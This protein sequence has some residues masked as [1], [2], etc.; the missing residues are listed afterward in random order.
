MKQ[1]K[2]FAILAGIVIGSIAVRLY[3]INSPIADWHSW[4]QVDTAAVARNFEKFGTDPLHPRYNDLSNIQS[5]KDN[6][7][8]WRMVEFPI[9]QLFAIGSKRI[10][11]SITIE[12]A[13][14]IVSILATA[15][16]VL[17]LGLIGRKLQN[18]V[19]GLFISFFYAFLPY[20]IYYGRTTLPEPTGVFFSILSLLLAVYAFD[21]KNW[22]AII[23]LMGS[24]I[25]AALALLIKPF[26][27]FLLF[28]L[29]FLFLRNFKFSISWITK[30]IMYG[31]VSLL[32]LLLWRKWILQFPEGIPVYTWLF[33]E[34]NIRF[35]GA[36]FYWLF[37]E[38]LGKLILGYW[39]T[40]FF[41]LGIIAKIEKLE[42][43]FFRLLLLGSLLCLV[44][45]A[46]GNVQHDY[47]QILLV[48]VVAVYLGKG[49]YFL[50]RL[51]QSDRFMTW[52][53]GGICLLFMISFSWYYIR[54]YYWINHQEIVDAGRVADQILPKD[55]KVI[56]PYGGDTTFL[57]QTNRQGWPIGFEIDKKI[58]M[59]A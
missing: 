7:E 15:G 58:A 32:P 27:G 13:L 33:N 25:S 46:R 2:F 53:G 35:K 40:L 42:H 19:T 10:V 37:A 24:A 49:L 26:M 20:S 21:K 45:V 5:G 12:V 22:Q 14:R 17:S 50:L 4:R 59:G 18:S 48:P 9:Y 8:G 34:G 31:I 30:T 23:L 55:A 39:G 57:Y 54:S 51:P 36:W 38:R 41:S 52:T 3:K 47:Y 1:S 29:A 43:W 6:P 16:T 28:P 11:P 56:A 44:I